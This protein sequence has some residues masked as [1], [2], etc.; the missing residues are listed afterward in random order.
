MRR[1]ILFVIFLSMLALGCFSIRNSAEA[2]GG[3]G[4]GHKEITASSGVPKKAGKH[5]PSSFQGNPSTFSLKIT[6]PP[7]NGTVKIQQSA[8]VSNVIYQSKPGF[9]GK[10]DFA[11]VRVGSDQF[12]GTYTV[13]VTVK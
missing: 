7:R 3:G 1:L 5:T 12:A 6:K 10:D 2:G 9:N 4:P 11:Y 8:G 13:A